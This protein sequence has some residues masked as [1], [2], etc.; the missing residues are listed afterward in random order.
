MKTDMYTFKYMER[1]DMGREE[2]RIGTAS[3][4]MYEQRT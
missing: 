4:C 3:E 1:K 2:V